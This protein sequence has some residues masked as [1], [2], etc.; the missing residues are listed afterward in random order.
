MP[1]PETSEAFLEVF[2]GWWV[3]VRVEDGGGAEVD[4]FQAVVVVALVA[5]AYKAN[6]GGFRDY[7][8]LASSV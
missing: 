1:A 4:F 5:G 8:N 6:T 7:V 2:C 3:G